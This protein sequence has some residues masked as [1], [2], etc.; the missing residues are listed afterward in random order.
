MTMQ[1][2]ASVNVGLQASVNALTAELELH[3]TRSRRLA[4]LINPFKVSVMP[5]TISG[6]AGSGVGSLNA[7]NLLGPQIGN[8][9]D[10]RCI[11]ASG[12]TAGSVSVTLN[13]QSGELV[14]YFTAQ[15]VQLIGKG[16][17]LLG[18]NDNLYFSAAGITSTSQGPLSI[19]VSGITIAA[20]LI[21]EYLL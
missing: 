21:G 12:F 8:Y 3:R 19:S 10:I 7:P 17:I 1:A 15:G 4:Q 5:L 2:E 18:G 9:W 13:H 20:P 6:S 16:Q 14:A 11:Q